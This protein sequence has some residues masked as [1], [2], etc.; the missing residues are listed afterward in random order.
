MSPLLLGGVEL[1]A[2]VER[3][4][5]LAFVPGLMC[6]STVA[7][8]RTG[9]SGGRSGVRRSRIPS[10]RLIVLLSYPQLA[11]SVGYS[12]AFREATVNAAYRAVVQFA[13]IFRADNFRWASNTG[14]LCWSSFGNHC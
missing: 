2:L 1:C 11:G 13:L 12:V 4:Q 9:A 14:R 6:Q 3:N 5:E 7:N 10:V 8:P